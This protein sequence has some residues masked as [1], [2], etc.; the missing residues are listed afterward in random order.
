MPCFVC[1]L[2]E[3]LGLKG[4]HTRKEVAHCQYALCLGE[5]ERHTL[6]VICT[7]TRNLR[8]CYVAI[9]AKGK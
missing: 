8:Y 7:T 4:Y 3:A 5:A 9:L 2:V 1:R 6:M